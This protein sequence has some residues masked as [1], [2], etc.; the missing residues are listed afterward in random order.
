[1]KP[2]PNL[3]ILRALAV[4]VVLVAHCLPNSTAQQAA[5]RFGVLIFFVHTALVLLLSLE[6]Q[7][8]LDHLAVRF[9]IQRAFRIYPLSIICVLVSLAFRIAWPEPVFIP[10]SGQSIAANLLLVQNFLNER[11]SISAPLWSL[12]F[13]VQ[14]YAVLPAVFWFL[15][16]RPM[17]R[18]IG[19]VA[20]SAA[21]AIAEALTFPGTDR[22]ITR[23]FPCFL[24]GAMAYCRYGS[25]PRWPWAIWPAA[26]IA[27]G[28]VY[29]LFQGLIPCEWLACTAL[30]LLVPMF[31]PAPGKL[32]SKASGL[33]ARYSY[34]IYL[35]HVPLLWLCFQKLTALPVVARWLLFV[36]LICSL[37]IGLYHMIEEPMIRLGKTL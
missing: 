32:L 15:R 21:L 28:V 37:P 31:H 17:S 8:M 24:A 20:L 4:T 16:K 1:M 5:G 3:D 2:D 30:G 27:L 23:Y 7:K 25:T 13:E 11:R 14:M 22:W 9:Y 6:R 34:G 10:R 33:V 36:A 29:C 18:A 35:S 26:I 19:L 12:P